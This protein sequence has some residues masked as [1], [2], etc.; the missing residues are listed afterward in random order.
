MPSP[1]LPLPP[2]PLLFCLRPFSSPLPPPPPPQLEVESSLPAHLKFYCP[3]PA[4]S[5]LMVLDVSVCVCVW[6]GGLTF[7]ISEGSGRR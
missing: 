6:G 7:M 3:N 2:L 1:P 4:C 5:L